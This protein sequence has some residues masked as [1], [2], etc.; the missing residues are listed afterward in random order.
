MSA[1][2]AL[3]EKHLL[4]RLR[5]R[6][7]LGGLRVVRAPAP[8]DFTS[9]VA[10]W[11][12]GQPEQSVPVGPVRVQTVVDHVVVYCFDGEEPGPGL[13]FAQELHAALHD[14][15]GDH[16]LVG[17][18]FGVLRLR[19]VMQCYRADSGRRR[20]NLG[21]V[22]RSFCRALEADQPPA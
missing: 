19:P 22:Y 18:V 17:T 10:Y 20:W 16:P 9:G 14:S 8:E 5:S 15:S 11:L 2:V 21:G 1:D 13:S 3:A 7:A 12:A 4:S 6:P